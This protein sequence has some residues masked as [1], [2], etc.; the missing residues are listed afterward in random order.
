MLRGLRKASGNWLGKI[1]M[2]VVVGGLVIAF[3]IWG[4]GDIFR[5]FGLSTVAKIGRTEISIDEF[6]VRYNDQLQQFGRQMGRPISAEQAR[7]FGVEQQ[8]LGQMIAFAALDERARQLRLRI[9]D[10]DL[11]KRIIENPAFRGLNGSFDQNLFLQRIRDSGFSEQRFALE[12]RQGTLRRQLADA[13]GGEIATPQ[14][15]AA[16]LERYGDEE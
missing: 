7:A 11:R 4:I 5:G 14:A 16:A 2:A 6:R 15:V 13:I 9:S 8:L 10:D 1:V 3:G 12:Q